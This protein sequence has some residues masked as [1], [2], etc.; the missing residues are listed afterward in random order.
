MGIFKASIEEMWNAIPRRTP[1]MGIRMLLDQLVEFPFGNGLPGILE[2]SYNH[3]ARQYRL[4][5]RLGNLF[6]LRSR[7]QWQA[8][9]RKARHGPTEPQ[10]EFHAGH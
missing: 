7:I 6:G 1:L 2:A 3:D 8:M 5:P 4:V 9:I 10:W